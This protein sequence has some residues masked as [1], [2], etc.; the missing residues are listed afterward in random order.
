MY[1]KFFCAFL[2]LITIISLKFS[3]SNTKRSKKKIRIILESLIDIKHGNG[4]RR[5]LVE[6][7]DSFAPLIYEINEIVQAY[8]E[9][10]ASVEQAK[11]ENKQ[12][13]TSLS[14]D[15]RTPLTTLIGYLDAVY[16]ERIIGEE[17]KEYIEIAYRKACDLKEYIDILFDWFK[18]NSNEFS[19]Q[20]QKVEVAELTRNILVDWIP[21]VEE[22]KLAYSF[23]I[24]DRPFW[25]KM[26]SVCY[27]RIVNNLIQNI[28]IHSKATSFALDLKCSGNFVTIVIKDNG[29]GI[30]E[31]D[32]KHI[33]ERL[34]KCDKG[35]LNK[36]SGLGLSIVQQLVIKMAG[37]INV[38]SRVEHGSSFILKFPRLK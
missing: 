1:D 11:E 17:Q 38:E 28:I 37:E 7:Y 25:V 23:E 32:L 14:H 31:E 6:P 34:Y 36:G 26:D 12:L 4:N 10:L 13:M 5:I 21:I 29:I 35:R 30:S 22:K 24:P 18:L 2:I 9:K 27:R 20:M 15:I 19:I 16:K 8:E 33:F 3:I